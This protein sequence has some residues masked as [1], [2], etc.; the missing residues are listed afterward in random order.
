MKQRAIVNNSSRNWGKKLSTFVV[1]KSLR[2][3]CRLKAHAERKIPIQ[4]TVR[5]KI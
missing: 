5:E 4:L 1:V 3:K 2:E